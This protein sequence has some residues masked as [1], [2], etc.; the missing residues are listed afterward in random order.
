MSP[1]SGITSNK[2]TK[3]GHELAY[4]LEIN[5]SQFFFPLKIQF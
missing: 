4:W 5:H 3:A 1:I 2:E